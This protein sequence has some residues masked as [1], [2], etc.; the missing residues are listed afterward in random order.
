MAINKLFFAIAK[1]QNGNGEVR[2]EAKSE[3]T[4]GIWRAENGGKK[5]RRKH[6]II[7]SVAEKNSAWA[8]NF[9]AMA[10]KAR[11]SARARQMQ[12]RILL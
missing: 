10:E 1:F 11:S 8:E 7:T 4:A 2:A 3:T 12:M 9:S 5:F 6:A